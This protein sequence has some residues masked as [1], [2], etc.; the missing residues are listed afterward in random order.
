MSNYYFNFT[1]G[2]RT[3]TD[4]VGLELRGLA[5]A[6]MEARKQI[7]EMRICMSEEVN[8]WAQW[9][10]FVADTRG[11]TVFEIGFDLMSGL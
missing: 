8:D 4:G 5:A 11:R 9:K 10:I 2:K 6:R 1:D 3:F 7:R